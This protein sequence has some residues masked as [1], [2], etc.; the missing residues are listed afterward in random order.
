MVFVQKSLNRISAWSR[1]EVRSRSNL[2]VQDAMQVHLSNKPAFGKK[3][4][5]TET[6]E[7]DDSDEEQKPKPKPNRG[8]KSNK[9]STP[10]LALPDKP[11]NKPGGK[12]AKVKKVSVWDT[13]WATKEERKE[14]WS[15]WPSV[16][17]IAW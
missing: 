6:V 13:P 9:P 7:D 5:R 1:S 8:S 10:Q 4:D 11:S 17:E 12:K 2:D 16:W 14:K 3:A 15:S